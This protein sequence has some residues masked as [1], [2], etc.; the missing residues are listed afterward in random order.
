M[1]N[2]NEPLPAGD[3]IA[4]FAPHGKD[5]PFRY[6]GSIATGLQHLRC[7]SLGGPGSKYLIAGGVNG[8]GV[9]VFERTG[10]S[11]CEIA[12]VDIEKPTSFVWL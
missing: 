4:V 5:A 6:L 3:T 10:A 12:G 1:T 2:R 11:L 8:G 9:K 7:I